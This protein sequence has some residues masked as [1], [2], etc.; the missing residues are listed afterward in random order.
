MPDYPPPQVYVTLG[1][2]IALFGIAIS[3]RNAFLLGAE[4]VVPSLPVAISWAHL[5]FSLFQGLDTSEHFMFHLSSLMSLLASVV[6]ILF[7]TPDTRRN[8]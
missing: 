1:I 3:S 8:R 6:F 4:V 2:A 7:M 5:V